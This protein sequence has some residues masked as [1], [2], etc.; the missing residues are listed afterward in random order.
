MLRWD[1]LPDVPADVG[2]C[3]VTLGNFDGV[4][5]G[6]RAVL[7]RVVELARANGATAVAVTFDPHP[8]AVLHPNRAPELITGLDQRLELIA[9]AGVDAALVLPFTRE[10]AAQTPREWVQ[11]TFVDVLHAHTVVVGSDTRFG[12][13]NSG[14][15]G[16]LRELGAE[17][18]FD[19]VVVDDVAPA[20]DQRRWSSSWVRELLRSGDVD[21]AARLLGRP[22]RV[23]GEVVHGDHRGRELG[24]P[25]ANLSPHSEGMVPADGVYAGWLL[26]TGLDER[27]PERLLPCAVSIGTNP[28]FDG[29]GRRVE[30]YVLDRTDLDLYGETIT[31]ELVA[32]LR[33]TLR[34]ESV[35]DLLVQMEHDVAECRDLLSSGLVPTPSDG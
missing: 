1:D 31:L 24:Y 8:L 10:L 19:V 13:R 6:H 30:A 2:P 16:T 35:D 15:V 20:D 12:V 17:L 28:T 7:G 29:V 32:R 25:T 21:A 33:E 3:V 9:D 34:F 11:G 22:H 14:D 23:T 26:R 18:G 27:D 5:A 4:H